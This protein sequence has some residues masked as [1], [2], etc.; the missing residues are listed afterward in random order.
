M[1]LDLDVEL[2]WFR[3]LSSQERASFLARLSHNLTIAMR[4]FC[5]PAADP[6]NL[7]CARLVNEAHHEVAG[8]LTYCLAGTEDIGWAQPVL[9]R[10]F[11]VENRLVGHQLDQAWDFSRKRPGA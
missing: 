10:I 5:H 3:G 2:E 1:P 8:Y 11:H 4:C 7:E 6:Q 9:S